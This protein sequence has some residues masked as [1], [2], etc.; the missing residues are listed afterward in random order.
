[1]SRV[2]TCRV[3]HVLV[4]IMGARSSIRFAVLRLKELLM[5][6]LMLLLLLVARAR[7]RARAR[8]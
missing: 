4:W 6:L 7:T 3:Y 5:L 2:V 1:M 8:L